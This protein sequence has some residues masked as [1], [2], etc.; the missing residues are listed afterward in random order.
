ME[1]KDTKYCSNLNFNLSI[2]ES[3]TTQ[4]NEEPNLDKFGGNFVTSKFSAHLTRIDLAFPFMHKFP[5]KTFPLNRSVLDLLDCND[6]YFLVYKHILIIK[7]TFNT[8][9]QS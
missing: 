1:D 6:L 5:F 2:L 7:H 3:P 4:P 8:M 9:K